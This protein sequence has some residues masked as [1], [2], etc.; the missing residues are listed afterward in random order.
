M[1]SLNDCNALCELLVKTIASGKYAHA[2]GYQTRA[3]YDYS[4]AAGNC[5]HATNTC[6]TV[7]GKYNVLTSST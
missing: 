5:T 3:T 1:T 2:E 7:I 6:Q 4:H